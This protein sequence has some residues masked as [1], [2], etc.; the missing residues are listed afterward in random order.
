LA[1]RD[2]NAWPSS[3]N[4]KCASEKGND[5]K[6]SLQDTPKEELTDLIKSVRNT[7]REE[8]KEVKENV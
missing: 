1:S 7:I 6:S 2:A 3:D 8:L 5:I 4:L